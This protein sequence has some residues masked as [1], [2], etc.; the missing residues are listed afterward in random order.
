[1]V[2]VTLHSGL[3]DCGNQ[4]SQWLKQQLGNCGS[5]INNDVID[6]VVRINDRKII[7]LW[8]SS[9]RIWKT[10]ALLRDYLLLQLCRYRRKVDLDRCIANIYPRS[11]AAYM[12]N[13]IPLKGGH[14]EPTANTLILAAM[15]NYI[16]LALPYAIV[17]SRLKDSSSLID[18]FGFAVFD[19]CLIL[20]RNDQNFD[21]NYAISVVTAAAFRIKDLDVLDRFLVRFNELYPNVPIMSRLCASY[22]HKA[23]VIVVPRLLHLGLITNSDFCTTIDKLEIQRKSDVATSIYLTIRTDTTI[24]RWLKIKLMFSCLV[25]LYS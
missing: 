13:T 9:K 14:S 5:T 19:T 12:K 8:L 7:D 22:D 18:H 6:L 10:R 3:Y 17:V 16:R 24:S 4:A 20:A 23:L 15:I 2:I 11:Q 21:R 1:M 25:R